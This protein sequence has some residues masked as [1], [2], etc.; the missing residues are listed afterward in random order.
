MPATNEADPHDRTEHNS[1]AAA[2]ARDDAEH[3]TPAADDK[4]ADEAAHDAGRSVPEQ[5]GP[6]PESHSFPDPDGP[7]VP[8]NVLAH[9]APAAI[10]PAAIAP[11][12]I[13][14]RQNRLAVLAVII[15]AVALAVACGAIV[16]AWSAFA[17]AG[18]ATPAANP[19]SAA[20]K[21]TA[22]L[23]PLPA[24]FAIKY[25]QEPLQVPAG[26]GGDTL[27]DLDSPSIDATESDADLR[28]RI[29]CGT[30]A[31]RL[32]VQL[33]GRAGSVIADPD[34]DVPEC[35]QAIRAA[36]LDLSES[37]PVQTGTAICAL[38]SET[39]TPVLALVEITGM[40]A[41]GGASLRASAWSAAP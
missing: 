22:T 2:D 11:G 29:L 19:S 39:A 35:V 28:F 26:C 5:R 30:G 7:T 15:A 31:P 23:G 37:V 38:T 18:S 6:Y 9:D 21:A 12:G 41:A 24:G 4:T 17:Q 1:A 32:L 34:T 25:A 8:I 27:V 16:T 20:P 3:D 14:H 33:T 10:A 40:D 13:W 36:P